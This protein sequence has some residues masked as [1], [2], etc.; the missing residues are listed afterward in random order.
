MVCY[1]V[2]VNRYVEGGYVFAGRLGLALFDNKKAANEFCRRIKKSID[3]WNDGES[4]CSE[5]DKSVCRRVKNIADSESPLGSDDISY[6]PRDI[7]FFSDADEC[8]ASFITT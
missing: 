6:F 5:H 8:L 3:N 7:V 4:Q 1:E 2:T